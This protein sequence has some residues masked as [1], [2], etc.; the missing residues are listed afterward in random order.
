MVVVGR[1]FGSSDREG[2]PRSRAR[3]SPVPPHSRRYMSLSDASRR[4]CLLVIS[5]SP[6]GTRF[7][8]PDFSDT[9]GTCGASPETTQCQQFV[10]RHSS[11]YSLAHNMAAISQMRFLSMY[12]KKCCRRLLSHRK[13]LETAALHFSL[14][15]K[16]RYVPRHRS[17]LHLLTYWRNFSWLDSR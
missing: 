10:P 4:P 7:N 13:R 15:E 17:L 3:R 8:V 11:R 16:I 1:I 12:R 5:D 9:T 6:G 2:P 14:V